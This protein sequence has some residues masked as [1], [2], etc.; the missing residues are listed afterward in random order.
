MLRL[1]KVKRHEPSVKRCFL[2]T[3]GWFPSIFCILRGRVEHSDRQRPPRSV[4]GRRPL[5]DM[6]VVSCLFSDEEFLQLMY[7]LCYYVG[8]SKIF[9]NSLV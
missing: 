9:R 4:M 8:A 7:A 3:C 2:T 5:Y 6:R 1:Y